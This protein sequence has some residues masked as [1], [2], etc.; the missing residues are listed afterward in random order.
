MANIT[1][2]VPLGKPGNT[3]S[4][5]FLNPQLIITPAFLMLIDYIENGNYKQIITIFH[6][7]FLKYNPDF[8]IH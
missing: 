3:L 6:Y 7:S 4:S 5:R 8:K 2:P 1:E